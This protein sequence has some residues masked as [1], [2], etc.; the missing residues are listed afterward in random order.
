LPL[1]KFQ[2]SYYTKRCA[3]VAVSERHKFK[4]QLTFGDFV[5][6]YHFV[7]KELYAKRKRLPLQYTDSTLFHAFFASFINCQRNPRE[8]GRKYAFFENKSFLVC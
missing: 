5:P 6:F 8:Q 3:L 4:C 1:L 2:P 7:T